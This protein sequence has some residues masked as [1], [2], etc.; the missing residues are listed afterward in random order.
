MSCPFPAVWGDGQLFA[1]SGI[2]GVASWESGLVASTQANPVGLRVRF[3]AAATL[4][5]DLAAAQAVPHIVTGDVLRLG[6]PAGELS[7]ALADQHTV[8]GTAAR[9]LGPHL[10]VAEGDA[11]AWKLALAIQESD[12]DQCRWALACAP[13]EVEATARAQRALAYDVDEVIAQ[14]LAFLERCPT[15]PSTLAELWC[16]T[17]AKAWSVL[18]VNTYSAEGSIP[19]RW[20]TPDRWPHRHM[21]L[22][23]SAFHALGWRHADLAMAWETIEAV[24]SQQA[25][26]GFIAHTLS[27]AHRSSITQ[28]PIL[29]W[30]V[31]EL[32]QRQHDCGRLRRAYP[33]LCRYLEWD[34]AHRRCSEDGL[35]AWQIEGDPLCRSGESGMDNSPRFDGD[36][37]WAAVDFSAYAAAE[38][39][40]LAR[41]ACVLG[42]EEEVWMWTERRARMA[43][44]INERLWDEASGFYYDRQ[45]GGARSTVKAVSGF[46]PLWAGVATPEQAAR[47]V[48]HVR[49]PNEF[50]AP[51]PLPSVA[52]DD[53]AHSE[54]MWRGSTWIN[55][56]YFVIQGLRRYGYAELAEELAGHTLAEIA[57]WYTTT[58]CL[59]EFYD[60]RGVKEPTSLL[61]KGAAAAL[62]GAAGG[63]GFGVV[64]DYGWTAALFIDLVM[65]NALD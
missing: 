14:R 48:E 3:P 55:T 25:E 1:F 37:P 44:A 21:W 22:W 51:F 38:M 60:C 39:D 33:I 45:V 63:A 30:A 49:D 42:Q 11:A 29:A 17:L 46:L 53:P 54:D 16:K 47:L 28:P 56:N 6:T 19:T 2:D 32:Y 31:W 62:T 5:F 43:A 65:S 40:A 58:G 12:G 61:R 9:V 34:L 13:T 35:L 18:K 59:H 26:D 36:G 4:W 7:L 10:V 15:P 50:W 23:D 20:T 27:P 52:L 57:R 8:V 64:Q 24:L 41:M